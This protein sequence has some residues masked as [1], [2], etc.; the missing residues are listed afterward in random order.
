MDPSGLFYAAFSTLGFRLTFSLRQ[1]PT[2][3]R[4]QRGT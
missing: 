4:S 1:T 3:V 2:A